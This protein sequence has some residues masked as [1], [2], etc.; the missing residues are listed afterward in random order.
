YSVKKEQAKRI[1]LFTLIMLFFCTA[2]LC[3]AFIAPKTAINSARADSTQDFYDNSA[4]SFSTD[5]LN[6][7]AQKVGFTGFADLVLTVQ[8]GT[9]TKTA[10]D[11]AAANTVLFGGEEWYPVYLSESNGNA[12]LTLW[13][14]DP[15][16]SSS[17]P[18]GGYNETPIAQLYSTSWVHACIN[19]GNTSIGYYYGIGS[20]MISNDSPYSSWQAPN[21]Y[22]KFADFAAGGKFDEYIITPNE[23]TYE[24]GLDHYR[25]DLGET[26]SPLVGLSDANY[27]YT[28]TSWGDDNLWLPSYGEMEANGLW[29]VTAAQ[30]A[31]SDQTYSR[32]GHEQHYF[33]QYT[34]AANGGYGIASQER[35]CNIRPAIHLNMSAIGYIA[36][37][38]EVDYNGSAQN[39]DTAAAKWYN[40]SVMTVQYET[41]TM[42]DAGE[43]TVNISLNDNATLGWIDGTTGTKQITFTIKPKVLQIDW[44]KENHIE[45]EGGESF[46]FILPTLNVTPDVKQYLNE[47]VKYYLTSDYNTSTGIATGSPVTTIEEG[48][49]YY[50]VAEIKDGLTKSN[51]S[52]S[53]NPYCLFNT[54]DNRT[55]VVITIENSG[56]V[57]DG[58]Q[59][60]ATATAKKMDGTPLVVGT[61]IDFSYT[62]YKDGDS[63]YENGSTNPPTNAGTYKL[64]VSIK[65]TYNEEYKPYDT[66]EFEYLIE[67]AEPVCNPVRKGNA[68]TLYV[69]SV[70]PEIVAGNLS[71]TKGTYA[72]NEG[73]SIL[74]GENTY[75]YTF[76]PTDS[77]NYK[78]Y[79]GEFKLTGIEANVKSISAEFTLPE[80]LTIYDS[81]SLDDLMQ[82]LTV[83]GELDNG[84]TVDEL[85]GYTITGTLTAGDSTLTVHYGEKD[86][87]C[88]FKV[89]GVV[90]C[91]L[92]G[93]TVDFSQDGTVYT[94][95]DLE[96]LKSM[97]TVKGK[98]NDGRDYGAIAPSD[99][100]LSINGDEL[101]AGVAEITATYWEDG[102]EYTTKFNVNVKAVAL[103]SLTAVFNPG[104]NEIKSSTALN[105]LK[106]WLT[107]TGT[108]NDGTD[109]GEISA[110]DYTLTG[111]LKSG[112]T[113]TITVKYQGKST[114]FTVEVA[115]S[116][117]DSLKTPIPVPDLKEISYSGSEIDILQGWAHTAL[118]DIVGNKYT[119]AG[120]YTLVLVIK[121]AD[122][123]KWDTSDLTPVALA[124]ALAKYALAEE[125]E[126]YE[127]DGDTLTAEWKI[128]PAVLKGT[129][130]SSGTL[131]VVSSS[132]KG[133]TDGLF[134]YKYYDK[135]GNEVTELVI[136]ASYKVVAELID[137]NNF[138]LDSETAQLT[139]APHEFTASL[140]AASGLAAVWNNVKNF[141]TKS[142][143]GLPIWCW[144]LIA[145]AVLILLIII[146]AVACKRRKNKE[147]RE[148]A[149]ARKEEERQR[150]E[151]ER[152][153][154]EEERQM[155]REKL[156]AERELAKA[157]QEAELEKIRAQAGMG[158]AGAGMAGMAG[159]AMQ[160]QQPPQQAQQPIIQQVPAQD[161]SAMVRLEMELA[162]LRAKLATAQ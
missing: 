3:C 30:C 140:P 82:Y 14:K 84:E 88:Q 100:E 157:K 137:T 61:D 143:A 152:Q 112:T 8:S 16:W 42:I 24:F 64:V 139:S 35:P 93:I 156:E 72:W 103:E 148:E 115:E 144:L 96:E 110:D 58:K 124:K 74:L 41:A 132:Y 123:Y 118:V 153:R 60:A 39:L 57:Y 114:T 75:Y 73:Q 151:E 155:Q 161:N 109:Y 135:D 142:A 127:I 121:D 18:A 47:E 55:A 130:N 49:N 38:V 125:F 25:N 149:K 4:D 86:L 48:K 129:W 98:Y 56:E 71:D 116:V 134:A 26:S 147:E 160:Q 111:T 2:I 78:E 52:F 133:S 21:T 128:A 10:A 62:Y 34:M 31:S 44:T 54:T 97:L 122:T 22:T 79:Q 80:G 19:A 119:A 91:V 136:G 13:L 65:P 99:Y 50:A 11:L 53:G 77:D 6:S 101:V 102:I 126:G 92:E 81:F 66:V 120:S 7:F 37:D 146:I 9:T 162:E 46:Y 67:K 95:T 29:K 20:G 154:R 43:Y 12:V 63:V 90:A 28:Y 107:V 108:N 76:T 138:V 59:H 23:V 45:G 85:Y 113:S 70:L 141:M 117:D 15:A 150:K 40:S 94:S 145:L 104:L 105:N 131:D 51:Y 89:E 106:K 68:T 1:G 36:Q 32:S 159:T 158:M 69:G 27:G 17:Y 33:W 5:A 83:S 87:T